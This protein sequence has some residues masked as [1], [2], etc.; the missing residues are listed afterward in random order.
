[1]YASMPITIVAVWEI[2]K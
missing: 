1:M 2:R